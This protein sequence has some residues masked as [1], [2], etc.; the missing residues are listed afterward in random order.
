[1]APRFIT[2]RL[3]NG[4]GPYEGRVEVFHD[5]EWGTVCDDLWDD[6][7][8]DVVCR[9]LGYDT[10]EALGYNNDFGDGTGTIWMD[11]VECDGSEASLEQCERNN[12][13]DNDCDHFE[14]AGV[15]C[16]EWHI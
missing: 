12:W 1:M 3:V 10:G 2:V 11:Q 8:A 9:S 4:R 16:C 13:G 7:D 5:G 15:I 6:R 14:D